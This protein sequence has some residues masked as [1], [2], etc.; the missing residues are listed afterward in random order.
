[1][2]IILTNRIDHLNFK[3]EKMVRSTQ[4]IRATRSIV[5]KL[6]L[7]MGYFLFIFRVSKII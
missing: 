5:S 2:I 6:S 7:F 1:M 4:V 3:N